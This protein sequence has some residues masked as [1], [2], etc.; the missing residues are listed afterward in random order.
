MPQ[1][2]MV[3]DIARLLLRGL[4]NN[5]EDDSPAAKKFKSEKFPLN[6]CEF[7]AALVVFF[8]FAT[9]LFYIYLTMPA[10]EFAASNSHA[11]FSNL[12]LLK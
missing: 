4:E 5:G 9:G 7:A 12:R 8:L 3:V 10:S 1:N 6:N 2:V 11:P